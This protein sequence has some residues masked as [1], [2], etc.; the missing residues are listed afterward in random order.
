[1]FDTG[2][3]GDP[4]CSDSPEGA[5]GVEEFESRFNL[6]VEDFEF[7]G[8][9]GWSPVHG[10]CGISVISGVAVSDVIPGS[11]EDVFRVIIVVEEVFEVDFVSG[12]LAFVFLLSEEFAEF[13]YFPEFTGVGFHER[14]ESP[15]AA[16]AFDGVS[17]VTEAG[18]QA[19]EESVDGVWAGFEWDGVS[20][21]E[22][23]H[24]ESH[25]S[26]VITAF[27]E[28]G[29]DLSE[30]ATGAEVLDVL[31]PEGD[32]AGGF[33]GFAPEC[34]NAGDSDGGFDGPQAFNMGEVMDSCGGVGVP[35][36]GE[37]A[38][39]GEDG[40]VE[41]GASAGSGFA[42]GESA[43]IEELADDVEEDFDA[44]VGDGIFAVGEEGEESLEAENGPGIGE[45][46]AANPAV[47]EFDDFGD[48][49]SGLVQFGGANE[50]IDH[51]ESRVDL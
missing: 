40:I 28:D 42:H 4:E 19:I 43:G 38:K 11:A 36:F 45:S 1:M 22:P 12:F 41:F 6:A 32:V 44:I 33:A 49:S 15:E 14:E 29:D 46:T 13:R 31:S 9:G 21:A 2:G 47:P 24:E 18:D 30:A 10:I 5:Y 50:S 20:A 34:E 39:V 25:C 51:H 48:E 7:G 8:A 17:V 16:P 35:F 23:L 37:G 3:T 26:D 27:E